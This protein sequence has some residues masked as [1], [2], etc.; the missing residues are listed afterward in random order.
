MDLD[1]DGGGGAGAGPGCT[2]SCCFE[3]QVCMTNANSTYTSNFLFYVSSG[4][5][6]GATAGFAAGTVFPGV[7]NLIGAGYGA[8]YGGFLS[9]T[10]AY[11]VAVTIYMNDK[12]VCALNYKACIL[13]KNGN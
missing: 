1:M 10:T 6:G 7:G 9:G 13:R 4:I 5:V 11:L 8:T 2:E 3:Y 12:K